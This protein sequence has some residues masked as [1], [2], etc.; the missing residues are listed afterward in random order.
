MATGCHL[1]RD[2]RRS[3]EG[4]GAMAGTVSA[5]CCYDPASEWDRAFRPDPVDVLV[6]TPDRLSDEICLGAD[7][8]PDPVAIRSAV[9]GANLRTWSSWSSTTWRSPSR[10]LQ[11][12]G[13][14]RRCSPGLPR[15]PTLDD[16]E[17]PGHRRTRVARPGRRRHVRRERR[18]PAAGRRQHRGLGSCRARSLHG[19]WCAPGVDRDL[20]RLLRVRLGARSV[21][22]TPGAAGTVTAI[23]S[24]TRH[25]AVS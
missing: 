24:T 5:E 22:K 2:P 10:V 7:R 3:A 6:G 11:M 21:Q 13:P 19:G 9:M 25:R 14:S 8:A 18:G 17:N 15:R 23:P 20:P 1:G 12:T 4:A 16:S